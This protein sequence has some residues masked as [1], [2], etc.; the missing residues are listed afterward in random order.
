L[1]AKISGVQLDEELRSG[2]KT[3]S[4]ERNKRHTRTEQPT[5]SVSA[6]IRNHEA[7][8]G[9]EIRT[10]R[11]RQADANGADADGQCALRVL[12]KDEEYAE[13]GGD[14]GA[15]GEG[16]APSKGRE[17]EFGAKLDRSMVSIRGT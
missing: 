7:G 16:P 15:A 12:G 13:P 9:S 2:W 3:R 14:E 5:L 4:K 1:V 8:M 17:D 6:I 11:A 10:H